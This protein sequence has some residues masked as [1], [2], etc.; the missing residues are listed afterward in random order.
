[1]K[2]G[3]KTDWQMIAGP[4]GNLATGKDGSAWTDPGR[5]GMGELFERKSPQGAAER[6]LWQNTRTTSV[7]CTAS[8]MWTGESVSCERR[9]RGTTPGRALI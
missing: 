3:E 9:F 1:M 6:K 5:R 7:C 2:A 4:L 8:K